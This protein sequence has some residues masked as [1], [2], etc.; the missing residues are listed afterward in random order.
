MVPNVIPSCDPAIKTAPAPLA[1]I[2]YMVMPTLDPKTNGRFGQID[3]LAGPDEALY[4]RVFGRRQR[5][6]QGR[7]SRFRAA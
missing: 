7:A 6:K 1:A 4:Y 5:G 2:H 3:V